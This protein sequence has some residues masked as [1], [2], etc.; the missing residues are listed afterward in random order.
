MGNKLST[1]SRNTPKVCA[2]MLIC[3]IMARENWT[4]L[5]NC[6]RKLSKQSL[7]VQQRYSTMLYTFIS[8]DGCDRGVTCM[9]AR[10]SWHP[11]T[12]GYNNMGIFSRMQ[13][14]HDPLL[15]FLQ[16]VNHSW[17]SSMMLSETQSSTSDMYRQRLTLSPAGIYKRVNKKR[18]PSTGCRLMLNPFVCY[19]L[20]RDSVDMATSA[21]T[22]MSTRS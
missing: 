7:T 10:S 8:V 6:I 13:R 11:H 14:T 17:C 1:F 21:N 3:S 20:N 2:T 15:A 16:R 9:H 18:V 4:R 22:Y 19:S 5:K 12:F